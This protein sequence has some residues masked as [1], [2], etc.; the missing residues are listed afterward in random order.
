MKTQQKRTPNGA[1]YIPAKAFSPY[2]QWRDYDPSESGRDL[3]YAAGIGLN[4]L[5]VWL[6]YEWWCE[7]PE[8]LAADFEHFLEAA[9]ARGIRIMPSLFDRYPRHAHC[10]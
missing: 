2:Q 9:A 4:A 7:Q 8:R 6:S 3:G 1:I 5:R 10:R